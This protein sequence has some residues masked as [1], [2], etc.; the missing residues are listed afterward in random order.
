MAA[1][2]I[3][4]L[5]LLVPVVLFVSF[6]TFMLIHLV[7]G[8]PARVQLGE[9]STPEALAALRQE[10]G[11]DRPLYV[12]YCA[13]AQSRPFMAIWANPSSSMSRCSRQFSNACQ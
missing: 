9:D 6:I 2:I 4:R 1:Y 7:P 3:R 5:L 11:L 10:L 13:L 12:Q 8:D